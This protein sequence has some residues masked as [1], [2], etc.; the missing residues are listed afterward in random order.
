MSKKF[1]ELQDLILI[2]T[3]LE[4]VKLHVDER[5]QKTVFPWVKRESATTI[6]KCSKFPEL[7]KLSD[8]MRKA[9]EEEDYQ[10]LKE[11]L[12]SLISKLELMIRQYYDSM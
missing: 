7:R 2:K 9:V 8:D 1:L 6:M 10:S 12:P 5:Q 4:K 3:S 11:I